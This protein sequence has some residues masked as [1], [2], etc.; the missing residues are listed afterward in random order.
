M[1]LTHV[2][3]R[4][5]ALVAGALLA[6]TAATATA[7]LPDAAADAARTV[8]E[9]LGISPPNA[10]TPSGANERPSGSQAENGKGAEI[11]ELALTTELEG[12]E[13]GAAISTAASDGKSQAGQHGNAGAATPNAGGSETADAASGGASA[14]GTDVADAASGGASAAGAA[15]AETHPAAAA[16]AGGQSH[17]P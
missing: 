16:A 5:A 1:Q 15:N 17:R 10:T 2:R 7:A 11:S 8:L 9:T 6:A 12:V 4:T 3:R 13:K 14:K